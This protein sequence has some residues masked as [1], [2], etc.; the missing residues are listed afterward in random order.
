MSEQEPRYVTVFKTNN[1]ALVAVVKSLFDD[2]EIRYIVIE[3]FSGPGATF[4]VHE[5]DVEQAREVLK[6]IDTTDPFV[7]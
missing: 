1:P 4:Q 3:S 2:I 6:D 5:E 7:Q